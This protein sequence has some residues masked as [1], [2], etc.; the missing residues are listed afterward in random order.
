MDLIDRAAAFAREKHGAGKARK[1]TNLPYFVHPE[2]VAKRL[3][4][5]LDADVESGKL[6]REDYNNIIAAAY[7]HDVVE[8]CG[9]PIQEINDRFGSTVAGMVA[10]LT[11]DKKTIETMMKQN[12]MN[13]HQAKALYLTE[14]IKHMSAGSRLIKL[15]DR[16][17]NVQELAVLD[18]V[19]EHQAW[20]HGYSRET[21]YILDHIT[22]T[23]N[24]IEQ[25]LIASIENLIAPFS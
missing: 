22:F 1:F 25:E 4:G 11:I 19:K 5:L 12:K 9:V 14:E 16:E 8:D 17:H 15:G 18:K 6:S 3:Q 20:V 7:L 24:R 2:A 23:P 10:E 13:K 21:R